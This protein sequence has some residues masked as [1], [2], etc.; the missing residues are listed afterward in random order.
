MAV[1]AVFLNYAFLFLL[2]SFKYAE[3]RRNYD[4]SLLIVLSAFILL[5]QFFFR[6]SLSSSILSIPSMFF[7]GLS[8]FALQRENTQTD[9]RTMVHL[10]ARLFLQAIPIA[11]ILFV[12]VPRLSQAPWGGLNSGHATTGLSARMSPGSIASLS[13]SQE[14]A[15]RVEFDG[16]PP[17]AGQ[18]YWRGPVLTGYDGHDWYIFPGSA[19]KPQ[20]K[21]EGRNL[22]Y[23][24]TMSPSYQSWLLALDTPTNPPVAEGNSKVQ[25][26]LNHE[27]QAETIKPIDQPFRYQATSVL[28][29]CA[30]AVVQSGRISLHAKPTEAW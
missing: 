9:T 15:F 30:D 25:I 11:T 5:T 26:R 17:T 6:Q 1:A 22:D 4:A 10:T 12:A 7:I 18:L 20:P 28:S 8:L 14:V 2:L 3:T 23:T 27:L 13:K 24:V 16:A 21:S 19:S 29:E